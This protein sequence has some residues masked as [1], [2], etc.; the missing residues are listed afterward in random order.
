MLVPYPV[1]SG[2]EMPLERLDWWFNAGVNGRS[3]N[4]PN[5]PFSRGN[6]I[7]FWDLLCYAQA[8]L[9]GGRKGVSCMGNFWGG[10][11]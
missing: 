6:D 9:G 8:D 10:K 1:Y 5:S 4:S 3:G 7:R 11:S 2:R